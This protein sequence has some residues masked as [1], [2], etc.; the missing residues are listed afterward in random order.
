MPRRVAAVLVVVFV[1]VTAGTPAHARTETLPDGFRVADG[2]R[3]VGPVFPKIGEVTGWT[4]VFDVETD[5]VT[6]FNGYLD[7]LEQ[8]GFS[9]AGSSSCRPWDATDEAP[10]QPTGLSCTGSYLARGGRVGVRLA[11]TVCTGCGDSGL[12]ASTGIL[13]LRRD[14]RGNGTY[15]P[16]QRTITAATGPTVELST[17]DRERLR[18]A[19][20]A[21][22]RTGA[23]GSATQWSPTIGWVV[24]PRLHGARGARLMSPSTSF[25]DRCQPDETTVLRVA[26]DTDKSLDALVDRVDDVS[27]GEWV[28]ERARREGRDV[29]Q[30]NDDYWSFTAVDPRRDAPGYIL[31]SLCGD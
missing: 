22:N 24:N 13:E 26:G 30:R 8:L 3:L 10:L 1:A 5:A 28:T 23:D 18:S 2:T 14:D 31:A 19:M 17:A 11:V 9:E 6:A 12:V 4:A 7:Q 29:T 27:E 21:A 25:G 16:D 20:R 15:V